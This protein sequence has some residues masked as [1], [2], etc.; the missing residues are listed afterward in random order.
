MSKNFI[1]KIE[2]QILICVVLLLS[3]GLIALYSAN[4]ESFKK[5][6][7]WIVISIPIFLCFS[8]IDYKLIARFSI[9]YYILSIILLIIVLFT[10]KI[11]GASSW[12]NLS[13]FSLQ[14]GEFGKLATIFFAATV[15]AKIS[16]KNSKDIN[17]PLNILKILGIFLVP[18]ILIVLQPDYGTAMA[19]VASLVLMLF[20]A[21]INKKY[22]I[23]SILIAAISL[24]LLYFFVLPQ[25]AKARIDV[26]LNPESDPR[27]D[28]YNIIQS[29]IAIGAGKLT[30]LG[31]LQGTQTHLGYLYPKSTDFIF[32]VIG[33]EF[34]FIVC[35]I[36]V[37]LYVIFIT[38]SVNIAKTASDN[39]GSYI[40]IGIIGMFL[41]H[42]LE[43]IG[44]TIGLLPITGVPLPFISYGG[45]ALITDVVAVALLI[46][47][48]AR[49]K[50]SMFI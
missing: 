23:I 42:I 39:L 33:E 37:I 47:I 27:G 25:H 16:D 17:K 31:W 5:Q 35:S 45:S 4:Q 43:N 26:Y 36:I 44:M 11:N 41:F 38:K 7:V 32:S 8:I 40:S 24:P 13:N 3:I 48:N 50:K 18:I 34:G 49:K 29:K 21:G 10:G 15:L 9:V 20:V 2:W 30:G 46:N 22:I 6:I 1:K 19:Y 12:F 28:G 14:P